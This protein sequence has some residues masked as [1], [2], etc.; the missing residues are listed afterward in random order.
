MQAA[1]GEPKL[2]SAPGSEGMSALIGSLSGE[3]PRDDAALPWWEQPPFSGAVHSASTRVD[4][5]DPEA[6]GVDLTGLG[7]QTLPPET[8]LSVLSAAAAPEP[9]PHGDDARNDNGGAEEHG[10]ASSAWSAADREAEEEADAISYEGALRRGARVSMAGGHSMGW[11][12]PRAGA[13]NAP[14]LCEPA[15]NS[16][17]DAEWPETAASESSKRRASVTLRLSQAECAQLK[18]RAAEAGLTVSAYIRSCTFEAEALRAQVRQAVKQLRGELD[19]DSSR[20]L[21]GEL[22]HEGRG[23]LREESH[24]EAAEKEPPA[25]ERAAPDAFAEESPHRW[26]RLRTQGKNHSAHA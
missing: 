14:S 4:S 18:Q 6:T 15:A 24:G 19:R 5:P 8:F 13:A 23:N 11:A 12:R 3:L 26:W 21:H 16:P 10:T 17:A 25:P 1:T 20:E 7:P 9:A 22:R 2:R